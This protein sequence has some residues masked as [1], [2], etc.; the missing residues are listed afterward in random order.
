MSATLLAQS[1]TEGAVA[2]TVLDASGAV[3]AGAAV[4][5]HNEGTNAEVTLITDASGYFRAPQL[6]PGTYTVSIRASGFGEYK[7][8]GVAVTVG[9]LTELHPSLKTGTAIESV[10]VSGEAQVLQFE[11]PEISETIASKEIRDLPLNGGRWSDLALLTPAAISDAN[12]FG[13]I[14]FR[15]ISPLMNNVEIEGADDNQA[16]F[17]EERGRAREGYSTSQIG[18]AEFQVNTGFIPPNMDAPW[19]AS[20]TR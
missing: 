19:A 3:V 13:L 5:L 12:G 4:T 8:N 2:A 17:A 20:S 9:S 11:S 14:V 7:A 18:I 1:T 6:A 16:F 10:E 15:G